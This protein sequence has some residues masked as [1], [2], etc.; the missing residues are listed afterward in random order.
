MLKSMSGSLIDEANKKVSIY[1]VCSLI[2]IDTEG[3]EGS[4]IK[5]YCPFGDFFHSDGG[6]E[7]AFRVYSDTNSAYCF[8]CKKYFS[9]VSLYSSAT[10]LKPKQA[11][12]DLLER[13]GHKQPTF[14]ELWSNVQ[15]KEPQPDTAMLSKALRL[16]CQRISS[17]W[18]RDQFTSEVA[19][20]L[21]RCLALL[22]A[23]R[24]TE[25][26]QYWLSMSKKIM[27]KAL[28]SEVR[29]AL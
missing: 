18:S 4:S 16:Y 23:V 10:D 12:E 6:K 21:D 15:P 27:A 22:D 28:D 7:P 26:A 3:R 19:E 2:G 11:A 17:D 29:D 1:L 20:V 13:I 14:E 25:D 5:T 24:T 9:P 8:S